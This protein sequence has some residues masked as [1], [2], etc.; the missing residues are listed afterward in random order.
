[1]S[2][3]FS[4]M[5]FLLSL[6]LL[7]LCVLFASFRF[8]FALRL[9]PF[10]YLSA[11]LCFLFLNF[12]LLPFCSVFPACVLYFCIIFAEIPFGPIRTTYWG[13]LLHFFLYPAMSFL[14]PFCFV[15]ALFLLRF[16]FV[17][18]SFLLSPCFVFAS[19]LLRYCFVIASVSLCFC[20]TFASSLPPSAPR[21]L[22]VSSLV[23]SFW[24][25]P[26]FLSAYFLF[27]IFL[28]RCS[29]FCFLSVSFFPKITD[30][31]A[32]TKWDV[33]GPKRKNP[34]SASDP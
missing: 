15:V 22:H 32:K 23:A 13:E 1:M 10:C 27:A 18:A 21:W 14:L 28:L 30:F 11:L 4:G 25:P 33:W 8:T 19:V 31:V 5:C 12:C 34:C 29:L 20:F 2:F 24:L 17:F 26:C 9:H 6:A 3:L 16:C 7:R